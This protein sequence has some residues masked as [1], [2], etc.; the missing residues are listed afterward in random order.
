[1]NAILIIGWIVLIVVSLKGAE[2][3]LKKIDK[4]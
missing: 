3:A 4:L 1:M 2:V